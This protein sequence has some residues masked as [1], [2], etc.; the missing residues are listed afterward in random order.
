[1]TMN[2]REA[3][4]ALY[5]EAHGEMWVHRDNWLSD[6]P[7]GQWYGVR[8][9]EMSRRVWALDLSS[10]GLQGTLTPQLGKLRDLMRLNLANNCLEGPIPGELAECRRLRLLLLQ[11]NEL[12][13]GIPG[14]IV[15]LREL[16][17][18]A[19]DNNHLEG[20]LPA[21][22]DRCTALRGLSLS[23]CR[24][25]GPIPAELSRCGALTALDLAHNDLSGEIPPGL[26]AFQQMDRLYLQGNA[27]RGGIPEGCWSVRHHDLDEVAA[28][29]GRQTTGHL[30]PR[31]VDGSEIGLM[32][33]PEWPSRELTMRLRDTRLTRGFRE[34]ELVWVLYTTDPDGT[35]WA[36]NMTSRARRDLE[37]EE[38]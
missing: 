27:L 35:M 4:E 21:R 24:F 13:G 37:P 23:G 26:G 34:G 2:E 38:G 12:T 6:R 3:L 14:E 7:P 10:N 36:E 33:C 16:Q 15:H 18:I 20:P 25:S 30:L 32:T 11:D 1:M 5:R 22:L 29:L 17:E 19:L 31:S 9:D 28:E 8:T